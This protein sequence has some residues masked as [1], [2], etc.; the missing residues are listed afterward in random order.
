M[1]EFANPQPTDA[2]A[3]PEIHLAEYWSVIVKRRRLIGLCIAAALL[4][5]GIVSIFSRPTYKAT[6]VLDI[7]KD[8]GSPME[9]DSSASQYAAYDPEFLPTQTRL[10]KSREVAERVVKRLNLTDNT[11]INP[12]KSSFWSFFRRPAAAPASNDVV[13]RMASRL[14]PSID[15]VPV[16]GTNLVELSFVATSPKLA[17]D[18]ANSVADAYIDWNL[19]SKFQVVGQ[20]SQF[21]SAQIE[22]L[23]SEIDDK[24]RQLQAYG[25]Q[26]DIVS[27]DPKE[28]VTLQKLEALNRDYAAAVSDRVAKEARYHEVETVRA[29]TIA[30]TLSNGL[31][32]QLRNEQARLEREYAEKLNLFKPE[33][34]AMQELKAQID[35]GQQHLNTVIQETVAKA[36]A[37]AANDYQTALRRE[38][39]LQ[40]VLQGQK[41]EAMALNT[42]AV[43][44]N[45]L[46][47]EVETKRA[48]MDTL[49]KR[50]AETQV[51]SRLR[52]ERLSNVRVVDRALPP[53][54]RFRPSYKLNAM[55][56]LFLGAMAGIGLAFF[57]EYLDRSLRTPEQVE[58][59]LQLPALG[60]VAAVGSSGRPYGYGYGYSSRAKKTASG[61]SDSKIAIELLP[62]S[63]P[64]STVA[65]AY[66]AFRTALL[67]SRAGGVKTIAITS[68]LPA[69]GKT[70]TA[71]N[72]S[73]VLGQLGKRVALVD[74]DLHKPRLHEIFRLSNRVGLVSV[75]AENAVPTEALQQTSIPNVSVV[76][77]GPNSPNP[78]ALLS[79]DAMKRFLEFLSMNFDFVVVDTP[80]V[81]PVA[82]AFLIGNLVDGVVL[83]VRG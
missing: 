2:G 51:T 16:R 53:S 31:V 37:V 66:R 15:I 52:G 41:S 22:Q 49:L 55:L 38:Q 39:S 14:Q 65:E 26:V 33:W 79:S 45:N 43:E 6:V 7:E 64:R 81:S 82:D 69:E 46:K 76:T 50:N 57:L 27:V 72:L 71:L 28:N 9:I 4:I 47:V 78:S 77:S 10:M 62:H 42:N 1:S 58:R 80:P 12:P 13:A 48:L 25:R 59:T 21:L 11:E 3:Q 23:R 17:A 61:T 32:S 36:R 18:I 83:T 75:L 24:E 40:A 74:A 8:K 20:A 44:Y 54:A 29:D 68:S 60:V 56:S 5:G 34:P 19:E 35:K 30:D 67:L 63:Q 73:V 70:S